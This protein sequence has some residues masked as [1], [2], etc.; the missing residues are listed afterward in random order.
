MHRLGK[1][2]KSKRVK[3][4]YDMRA[5]DVLIDKLKQFEGYRAVMFNY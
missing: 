3:R 5:S 4:D 2:V 1:R